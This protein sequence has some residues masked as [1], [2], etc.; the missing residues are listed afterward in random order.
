[1][2][3]LLAEAGL[4]LPKTVLPQTTDILVS[5]MYTMGAQ[6]TYNTRESIRHQTG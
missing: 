1:M 4:L 5:H 2:L 3:H 6:Y